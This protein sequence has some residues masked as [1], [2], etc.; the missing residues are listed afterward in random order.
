PDEIVS[1]PL[2][3]TTNQA[4][5]GSSLAGAEVLADYES[6]VLIGTDADGAPV[7]VRTSVTA[8]PG[9]YRVD[10]PADVP[11]VAGPAGLLVHRHDDQLWNLHNANVRGHL[12]ADGRGWLLRPERLV[13]P[14][15][16]HR[17]SVLD[18]IRISRGCQAT[19]RRYL[20]HRGLTRP[21]VPWDAYRA[22]RDRLPRG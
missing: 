20:E 4:L 17:S 22:I 1:R 10:V 8:E 11:V 15:Q 18:P 6:V 3:V 7:L 19:T 2:P 13:E 16:K 5:A 12:A 14:G 21:A 9:G